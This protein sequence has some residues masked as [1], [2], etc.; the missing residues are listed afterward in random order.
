MSGSWLASIVASGFLVLSSCTARTGSTGDASAFVRERVRSVAAESRS[1][2]PA[3]VPFAIATNPEP[4]GA[5]PDISPRI[6]SLMTA[7]PEMPAEAPKTEAHDSTD[8]GELANKLSNPISSLISV[9]FQSNFDFGGGTENH[10]LKYTLN[11]QPVI[12]VSISKDFNLITRCIIPIIYQQE[13]FPGQQD[14]FGLGDI[15]PT[16][17][18]SPK[19]EIGGWIV[20]VGPVFLLPTAT[21]TALGTGKWCA[22]PSIVL[23][24]QKS[25]FTYG[26][27]ANHLW[28]FAGD[29]DRPSVNNTF[30]QPFLAYN[31]KHGTGI[32]L[33]TEATYNWSTSQWTNPI[34]LFVSQVIRIGHQPISIQFGPRYYTEGPSGGPDWGLRLNI[35]F[36]FPK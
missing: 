23:L 20:G 1:V 17:F 12:P 22:G 18:L 2:T 28:S 24:Q 34:G 36:L 35:T 16:F 15:N 3:A 26:I 14:N 29:D 4:S 13:Q 27:L 8:A 32:T 6:F 33:D 21:D 19:A 5:T 30:L 31:T 10:D 9:P 11:I 7:A 25:G